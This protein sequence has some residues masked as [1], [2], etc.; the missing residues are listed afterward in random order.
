MTK[1]IKFIQVNIYKGKYLDALLDFL[2]KEKPDFIAMQEVSSGCVNYYN[3][4]TVDLFEIIKDKLR[5][6]GVFNQ[7]FE[8][9]ESKGTFGNAVFSRFEIVKKNVLALKDSMTLP[10][11]KISDKS[12][13]PYIPR[14]LLDAT[15]NFGGQQI[16][17]ISWHGTW[18]APPTDTEETIRQANLVASYL[19]V[20]KEP[21]ILGGDLNATPQSKTV[22]LINNVANNLMMGSGV[23]ETTNLKVHKI[24]P[25]GFLVDY[26]FTSNHFKFKKITVPQLTVSDHLSVVAEL[27]L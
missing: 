5:L 2:V 11:K 8:I 7:D 4:K 23:T 13:F 3:D 20:L 14:H 19:K 22:G 26:V 16:H 1:S 18:T 21:F 27:E 10:F 17:A 24:A 12:F 9:L 6:E 15:I 25:R